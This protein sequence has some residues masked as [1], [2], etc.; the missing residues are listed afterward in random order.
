MVLSNVLTRYPKVRRALHS[1]P[2]WLACV[3][4]CREV[5]LS[6]TSSPLQLRT[7]SKFLSAS[8]YEGHEQSLSVLI[9]GFSHSAACILTA[10]QL[11]KNFRVGLN[12]S[13]SSRNSG[14]RFF[15]FF[16]C[17]CFHS[18]NLMCNNS[19]T[20]GNMGIFYDL[21]Q[22]QQTWQIYLFLTGQA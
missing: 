13:A 22:C 6:A 21:I 20:W 1:E 18:K 10:E 17:P 5:I 3:G 19:I 11:G 7:K 14:T 16:C 15:F 2:A 8:L 9:S 12:Y 4:R